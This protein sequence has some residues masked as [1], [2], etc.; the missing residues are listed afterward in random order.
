MT[1]TENKIRYDKLGFWERNK[2]SGG[3]LLQKKISE[4]A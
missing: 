2:L 1:N 3:Y 4:K